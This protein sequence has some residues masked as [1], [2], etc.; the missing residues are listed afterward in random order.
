MAKATYK[1]CVQCMTFNQSQYI[2]DALNGFCMQDTDFPFVCCIV[3][4][5]STDGEQKVITDYLDAYFEVSGNGSFVRETEYARI[6]F[7]RN[8]SNRNCHFAVLLLKEN[9]YQRGLTYL[10][11]EYLAEWSETSEY[12]AICEGDDYW[13]DPQKLQK[14]TVHM[15]SNPDCMLCCSDAAIDSADGGFPSIADYSDSRIIPPSD[16]IVKGGS[17]ICT[18]TC[19]FR[20]AVLKTHWELECTRTCHIGDWCWQ[21]LSVILGD[22]Y[23]LNEKTSCYRY[24]SS[25][26]WTRRIS[27]IDPMK[28]LPEIKSI[29]DMLMGLDEFSR[30]R[31]HGS[32]AKSLRKYIHDKALLF[33][34]D[35]ASLDLMKRN[36]EKAWSYLSL[37][38]RILLYAYRYG[39]VERFLVYCKKHL[40]L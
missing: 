20:P 32:F 27:D 1:V 31:F 11:A 28:R 23:F 34:K 36:C 5:A 18:C 29:A 17:W 33:C 21:I 38:Q 39:F 15:D 35:G 3:D 30:R 9:H 40:H 13:I 16:M 22:A 12:Q 37:R 4:D 10:K 24:I 7:A 14:Q 19:L 6:I 26:S 8:K 2:T 25:G